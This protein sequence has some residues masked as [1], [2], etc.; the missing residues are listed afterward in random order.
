MVIVGSN[1]TGPTMIE[2]E[3]LSRFTIS[4]RGMIFIVELD[5]E[6]ENFDFLLNEQVK[7]DG[8]MKTVT[9]VERFAHMP[10]WRKGE[11]IGLLVS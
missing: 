3:S 11:K 6:C 10:P 8:I 9:G 4:D 5:R 7:I 2:Y 1:P